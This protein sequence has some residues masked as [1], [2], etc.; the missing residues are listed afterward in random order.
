M[1][2]YVVT[3]IVIIGLTRA[4]AYW[5]FYFLKAAEIP[6]INNI[7]HLSYVE[8][9]G[10]AFGIFQNNSTLLS[11]VSIILFLGITYFVASKKKVLTRDVIFALAC[12]AGGGIS[13]VADRFTFGFVI[14][15]VYLKFINFAV[16]NLADTCVVL[17][18]IYIGIK[19]LFEKDE[20]VIHENNSG[21]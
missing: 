5:G 21:E 7:L 12:V 10:A 18:T 2:L 11:V 13:N 8:N 17:G 15:Y 3:I 1:I 4:L 9:T 20:E 14:D 19:I 6:V 16:F